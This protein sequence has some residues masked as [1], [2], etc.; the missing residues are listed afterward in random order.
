MVPNTSMWPPLPALAPV[1]GLELLP[2]AQPAIKQS[3]S[4]AKTLDAIDFVIDLL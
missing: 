4:M 2:E 1:R 3:A